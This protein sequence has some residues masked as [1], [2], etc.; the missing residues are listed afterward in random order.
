[1][2]FVAFQ[3][4]VYNPWIPGTRMP[5]PR[6]VEL[7]QLT[8]GALTAARYRPHPTSL[9]SN[10]TVCNQRMQLAHRWLEDLNAL[11]PKQTSASS[12]ETNICI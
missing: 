2:Y 7:R 12:A 11:Q 5:P 9:T 1:M 10:F 4:R 8:G 6:T 3:P